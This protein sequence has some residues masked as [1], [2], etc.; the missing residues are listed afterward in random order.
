MALYVGT[1]GW[2]YP[3]WQPGFY[4][5]GLPRRR[6]LEH[7]STVLGACEVNATFYRLQPDDVVRRWTQQTPDGFR[8]AVK[9]HRMLSH[10]R[11]QGTEQWITFLHEFMES[12]SP[13]TPRLGVFLLQLPA[14]EERDDAA[15][16]RMLDALPR[17]GWA[18]EFRHPSWDHPKVA[19]RVATR[20]HA[21]CISET[22]GRAPEVLPPGSFVYVRL[23]ADH[24]GRTPRAR[25]RSLLSAESGARD[26]YVFAKHRGAPAHDP[27][28]GVGLAL[29]LQRYARDRRDA[30]PADGA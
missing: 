20:G 25:W 2:A 24:Y 3:E 28:G 16:D 26:V 11:R 14:H 27:F 13:L 15:L 22:Q 17:G 1:S 5:A 10:S 6:W 7:L 30:R 19:Q 21:M 9:A 29:W 12:V 23:R 8:F 4:P 18:F